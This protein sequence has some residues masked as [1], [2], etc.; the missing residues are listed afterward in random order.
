[1]LEY[2]AKKLGVELGEEW[3]GNN[4]VTYI[5]EEEAIIE[6][7]EPDESSETDYDSWIM[8][9]YEVY[10]DILQGK[11]KPIWKPKE[12]DVYFTPN[13]AR[14]RYEWRADE[15]IC[16]NDSYDEWA[17]ERGLAF[18]T[19]KEAQA[20]ADKMLEAVKRGE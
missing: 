6:Y 19:K 20:V 15:V 11:L 8:S 7:Y 16:K 9:G 17:L 13:P 12:G 10:A 2:V 14:H 18:K 1:M 5:I 4:G 3:E